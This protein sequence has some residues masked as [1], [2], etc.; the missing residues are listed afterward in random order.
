MN[1]KKIEIVFLS[2]IY[3]IIF[4]DILLSGFMFELVALIMGAS[5]F[6]FSKKKESL[7]NIFFVSAIGFLLLAIILYLVNLD[8]L[9]YNNAANWSYIFFFFG[10]LKMFFEVVL[11]RKN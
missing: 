4:I 8:Y 1:L 2:I 3:G 7:S 6:L 11:E 5:L 9:P 10:I